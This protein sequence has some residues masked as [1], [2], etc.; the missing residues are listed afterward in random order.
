VCPGGVAV[1]V[2]AT[3]PNTMGL[4]R[5]DQLV[6][7]QA[8]R[9][10]WLTDAYFAGTTAYVRTLID[11]ARDGVDVRLLV[12][13]SSDLPVV[14]ALS[15]AGYRPLLEAGIRIFEWDG[16]MLHA[17]T[18]VADGSWAR[19]GSSNLN[20]ASWIGN[21]ELDIAIEDVAF[22][23]Q[24]E[25]MFRSDLENATEIVL[26]LGAVHLAPSSPEHHRPRRGSPGRVAAGAIGISSAVSAAITN[27]RAL[28][29]AESQVLAGAGVALLGLAAAAIF[30]PRLL[31]VPI[32][33]LA[34]WFAIAL[35]IRAW[36]LRLSRR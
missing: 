23:A 28:G 27:R 29:T 33:L 5:L 8:R 25:A 19:I 18:A 30:V 11:A 2:I 34:A 17:K 20:L 13:G 3:Q 24:M 10:L 21:W 36:Q 22:A 35:I 32:A 1:S 26:D 14:K 9:S 4:Y 7:M 31:T 12:P 6:A 16:P 15:R